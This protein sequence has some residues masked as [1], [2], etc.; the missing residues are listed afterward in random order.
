MTSGP[1][2]DVVVVGDGPA[3][4]ALASA[5]VDRG[6]QVVLVGRGEPW[7][8]TYGTWRDDLPTLPDDVFTSVVGQMVVHG[9]RR[10]VLTRPYGVVDNA[11]LRAHLQH[12][13]DLRRDVAHG[14]QH[15]AWGSRV[16]LGGGTVDTRLLVDATGGARHLLRAPVHRGPQ[17]A[18]QTAFGVVLASLPHELGVS[19]GEA[20]LMDLRSVPGRIDGEGDVPTFCYVVPVEG[21]WLVEET[22]LAARPAVA[23]DRIRSRLVARLGAQGETLVADAESARAVERVVIQMGGPLPDRHQTVAAFGAAA[24]YVHPATG[25]S[26]AASLRAA[27]RVASSIVGGADPWDAL[28]PAPRRR[29]RRLHDF[30]LEVLLALD[31]ASLRSFFDEFFDLPVDTWREYLRVDADPADVARAMTAVFSAAP[32]R[33]RRRLMWP[34]PAAVRSLLGR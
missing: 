19:P 13:V 12:A 18:F 28:W 15:F 16:L 33:L 2:L 20:I 27:E 22:V 17:P 32:A 3:G 21:G 5:C 4:S 23:P 25:F 30:G 7:S 6:L 9:E 26:L 10:H 1:D 24:G 31:A 11:A 8:A 14:S 34:G 29:T